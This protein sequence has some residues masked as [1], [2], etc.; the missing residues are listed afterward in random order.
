[1]HKTKTIV[2]LLLMFCT[3]SCRKAIKKNPDYEGNWRGSEECDPEIKI[4]GD[5]SGSFAYHKTLSDCNHGSRKGKV[6]VS[7]I[8]NTFMVGPKRFKIEQEP[9]TIDTVDVSYPNAITR[10]KSNIK[11]I[12]NGTSYY[13]VI[14]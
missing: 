3:F 6:R 4:K 12:L 1:M 11:M 14:E 10:V 13:K 9:T 2:L 8:G 7:I 5:G